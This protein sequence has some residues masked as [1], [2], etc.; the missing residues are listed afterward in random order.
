MKQHY[1][2]KF[3]FNGILEANSLVTT[4]ALIDWI[5]KDNHSASKTGSQEITCDF[6]RVVMATIINN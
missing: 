5:A 6:I 4:I 1:Q 3:I 2:I